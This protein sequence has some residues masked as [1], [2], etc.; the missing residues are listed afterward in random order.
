MQKSILK[1]IKIK[2]FFLFLF[3][4]LL[5]QTALAE[6]GRYIVIDK[7]FGILTLFQDKKAIDTFPVAFGFDPVSDKRMTMDGATPEGLY[8]ISYKKPYSRYHKFLGISY[9]NPV[10]AWQG[11]LTGEI[12]WE[13][14][15]AIS[16]AFL[17][18]ESP[19]MNT[20]LGGAVGI[21]G[22]GLYKI[23]N[24][25][26]DSNWTLGCIALENRDIERIYSFAME[27]DPVI[28][29]DSKKSLYE[30]VRSFAEIKDYSLYD[31]N[32][33]QN[34][35]C[36]AETGFKTSMG[37]IS[38]TI[39]EDMDFNRSLTC[40]V[41]SREKNS[42][43]YIVILDKNG[44]GSFDSKDRIIGGKKFQKNPQQTYKFV[45]RAIIKSI[46][47]GEVAAALPQARPQEYYEQQELA[48]QGSR[49]QTKTQGQISK[50]WH[51]LIY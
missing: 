35:K 49:T 43:P 24:G 22:G 45:R 19:P 14:H 21:H 25:K 18:K 11:L 40:Q 39:K 36:I 3:V 51:R 23:S 10:D 9:P 34:N 7:A 2:I 20:R 13:E 50:I 5:L 12:S 26:L 33:C 4:I 28:I 6:S 32:P 42:D 17:K 46:S 48:N 41:F 29:F 15:K 30:V 37:W 16:E 27:G 1:L 44:N 38:I 31:K 8:Y 47:N